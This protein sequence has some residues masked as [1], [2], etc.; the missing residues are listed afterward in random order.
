MNWGSILASSTMDAIDR[1]AHVF[2]LYCREILYRMNE[3]NRIVETSPTFNEA[4]KRV[5]D[6]GRYVSF[7]NDNMSLMAF[8][9]PRLRRC[10]AAMAEIKALA[11]QV[12]AFNFQD[13]RRFFVFS[14]EISFSYAA[15]ILVSMGL[16]RFHFS[17]S[18]TADEILQAELVMAM[19]TPIFP[20]QSITTLTK[21][22]VPIP[23][24]GGI[25]TSATPNRK[26]S[27]DPVSAD[28][29]VC[30]ELVPVSKQ[31]RPLLQHQPTT[32]GRH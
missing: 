25:T 6:T 11:R 1:V 2:T 12:F 4:K 17:N 9:I 29:M 27:T 26:R 8:E 28:G 16:R 3:L 21:T 20:I 15:K 13:E 19:Q 10:L 23:V 31:I 32:F 30:N 18:P 14:Q 5:M 22:L 24:D 7:T